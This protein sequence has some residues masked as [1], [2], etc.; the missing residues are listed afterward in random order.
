MADQDLVLAAASALT[1]RP[2]SRRWAH[3]SLCVLDAV[4]SIG[5]RY[6]S[7]VRTC[8][9]YAGH[10]GLRALVDASSAG[11]IIGTDA[12]QPLSAFVA[13]AADADRFAREVLSNRQRTSPRGGVLKAEAARRHAQILVDAGVERYRDVEALFDDELR[14]PP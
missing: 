1:V 5:A 11:S 8:E 10:A 4:F 14:W 6:A 2:R 12:E 9:R 7:T 3:M 13:D